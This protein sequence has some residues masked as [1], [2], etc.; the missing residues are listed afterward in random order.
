MSAAATTAV[1]M[2]RASLF[3]STKGVGSPSEG[4]PEAS[5]RGEAPSCRCRRGLRKDRVIRNRRSRPCRPKGRPGRSIGNADVEHPPTTE[6]YDDECR[7]GKTTALPSIMSKS[8]A[9]GNRVIS[10]SSFPPG[11]TIAL[12][13]PPGVGEGPEAFKSPPKAS[14]GRSRAHRADLN[15]DRFK[16]AV[17]SAATRFAFDSSEVRQRMHLKAMVCVGFWQVF[18]VP[19]PP[20]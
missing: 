5:A 13:L 15:S 12:Q 3:R 2:R 16:R 14:K 20:M 4:R 8:R 6:A 17:R 11:R 1:S 9:K 19:T 18:S 10:T 7:S